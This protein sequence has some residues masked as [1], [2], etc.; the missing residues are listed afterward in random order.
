MSDSIADARRALRSG[1]TGEALVH[2]WN[3]LEESRSTEDASA[4][5]T[6]AGLAQRVA[7]EG[8][9]GE[10]SEAGRLLQELSGGPAD[11][12]PYAADAPDDAW[13]APAAEDAA[14]HPPSEEEWLPPD[15]AVE[16][17]ESGGPPQDVSPE[18]A[19]PP[20]ASRRATAIGWLIPIAIFLFFSFRDAFS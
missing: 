3:A 8:D 12:E 14:A 5:A 11:A 16:P 15:D 2:L 13:G 9:D 20:P 4:R 1:E 6:I 17:P 19:E 10:R 18:E 7:R